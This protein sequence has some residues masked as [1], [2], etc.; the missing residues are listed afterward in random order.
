MQVPDARGV[1]ASVISRVAS[2]NAFA[3]AALDAELERA[4]QLS[5][6]DRGLATELVYGTLRLLPWLEDRVARKATRGID[7]LDPLVRAHLVIAAYQILVLTRIPAFAA[8]SEA[9]TAIRA[10]RGSKVGGFANAVLRKVAADP[11][12]TSE[13]LA[14]A[15]LASIDP[16]LREAVVRS[17]GAEEAR[18][19]FVGAG[20]GDAVPPLGLRV[21]NVGDRDA[22]MARFREARQEG[23]LELGRVSPHAIRAWGV[24]KVGALPGWAEEPGRRRKRDRKSL[25]SRSTLA[26]AMWSSMPAPVGATRPGS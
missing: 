14:H 17:V 21:E 26:R 23:T 16:D 18:A 9:V 7:S 11:R 4:V 12:P 20:D 5:G 25:P 10:A 3:A 13:E 1:A 2:D 6:R 19:L 22:W 8:V 15:A 24:G